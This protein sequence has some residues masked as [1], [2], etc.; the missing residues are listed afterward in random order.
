M[1]LSF[2]TVLISVAV[3]LGYAVPGFLLRKTRAI[4]PANLGSLV[5][6]LIYCFQ[7][8]LTISNF[9]SLD[10]EKSLLPGMG[11][12]FVLS[13][14]S[15]VLGFLVVKLAF[16]KL[17]LSPSAKGVQTF[18]AVFG[19]C[20]F[21]GIPL[22]KAVLPGQPLAVL[23]AG[24]YIVTFNLLSWTLGVY[25]L[26]G[27]RKYI[28]LKS[29]LFNPPTVALVVA[30]PLFFFN[31]RLREINLMLGSAV[32]LLGSMTTPISMIIMG[33][34]LADVG[35]REFASDLSA[36]AV[37][38]LKLLVLPIM[39]YGALYFLPVSQLMKTCLVLITAMPSAASA[40]ALAEKFGGDGRLGAKTMLVCTL[41]SVLTIPIISVL[42]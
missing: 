15:Q 25:M 8:L 23:Y 6:V 3:L 24:V 38:A 16:W 4:T 42:L 39:L 30:L 31:V 12:M 29:L 17:K 32:D 36:Y 26:T 28:S 20:G 41:F 2:W 18:T 11:L 5:A 35:I 33:A 13:A 21:M 7:P 10:Y 9:Q 22:I 37:S 14:A 40:V 19:N 34:R 27:D 1:G